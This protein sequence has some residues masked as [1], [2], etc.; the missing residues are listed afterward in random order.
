MEEDLDHLE[1]LRGITR[2]LNHDGGERRG[3]EGE[4]CD[5]VE[6]S[7]SQGGLL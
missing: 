7:E 2:I 4:S 6:G 3:G 5:D 1:R